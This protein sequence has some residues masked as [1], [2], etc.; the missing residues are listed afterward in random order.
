MR[1][2]RDCPPRFCFNLKLRRIIVPS[3]NTA[4]KKALNIL[5]N[6]G[7][8]FSFVLIIYYFYYNSDVFLT[9]D[10]IITNILYPVSYIA[11]IAAGMT[12]VILTGGIDLSVGSVMALLGVFMVYLVRGVALPSWLPLL[13]GHVLHIPAFAALIVALACGALMGSVTGSLIVKFSIPPFIA[14]LAL[15]GIARG[16]ARIIFNDRSESVADPLLGY[17]GRH[18]IFNTIPVAVVIMVIVFTLAYIVARHTR[19]GRY[20]YA[21][22][23]NVEAARMSGINTR[24]VI[25]KV[26]V[27][28]SVLSGL[29]GILMAS[30]NNPLGGAVGDPKIGDMYELYA[31]A[32]VVVGGTSLSGGRGSVLGTLFG[33]IFIGVLNNGLMLL[34][35][36]DYWQL[37]VR[38]AVIL[39]AVLLDQ[40]KNK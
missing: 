2:G 27:I 15:M 29:S 32:A 3:G 37:V 25:L 16:I 28:C 12:F 26:Y 38:G 6:Y 1:G 11:I 30:R 13:G 9:V 35:V 21:I 36:P 31:I 5:S 23:G 39:A 14:T 8:Y 17:I 10:N 20:V 34:N 4:G 22:G 40:F 33:A 19:F 18:H 24:L 7:L